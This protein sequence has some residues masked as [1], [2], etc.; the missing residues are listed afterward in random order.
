[1]DKYENRHE[2][3]RYRRRDKL[4]VQ[5]LASN[6]EVGADRFTVLCHSCDASKR[7][8]K[9]ELDVE[10]AIKSQVDLWLK[11]EGLDNKFYLRGHICWC[12]KIENDSGLYLSGIELEE[13]YA[14]DYAAWNELLE[15][16]SD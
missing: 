15:S 6:A 2:M 9:L 13:A 12:D 4:F 16:F 1:M 8:L 5:L 3:H 10:L 14:T 7:G 11:F